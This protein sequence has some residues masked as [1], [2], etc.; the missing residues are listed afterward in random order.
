MSSQVPAAPTSPIAG[1]GL[2]LIVSS[3][4]SSGSQLLGQLIE[5]LH[6]LVRSL[7]HTRIGLIRALRDNHFHKLLDNAYVRLLQ[8]VLLQSPEPIGSSRIPDNCVAGR[9]RREVDVL[10]Y[11]VQSAGIREC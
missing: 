4:A 7:D 8:G 5:L 2:N 6:H 9:S 11:A 3:D 1:S 10:T